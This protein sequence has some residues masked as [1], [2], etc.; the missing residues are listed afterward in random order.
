M[1]SSLFCEGA[2]FG[3]G[4]GAE[5]VSSEKEVASSEK[6]GLSF[7]KEMSSCS[8]FSPHQN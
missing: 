3:V 7:E 1:E 5:G 8:F 4:M 6:K 2:F